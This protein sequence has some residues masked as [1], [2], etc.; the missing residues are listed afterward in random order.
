MAKKKPVNAPGDPLSPDQAKRLLQYADVI[1]DPV[2]GDIQLTSLERFIIDQPE[3]QRLMHINQLGLTYLVYPGALHNRFLHSIGT[4]H[5]CQ[6]MIDACNMSASIYEAFAQPAHPLPVNV[7]TYPAFLARLCAL[8]HDMAHVPFGHIFHNQAH[9]FDR[10]EWED[11]DRVAKTLAPESEFTSRIVDWFHSQAG[12]R[13]SRSDSEKVA[14]VILA[15]VLQVLKTKQKNVHNLPYPFIHDL[16]GNTICADLLDYVVRD[17]KFCGLAERFGD[18]FTRHLGVVPVEASTEPEHAAR[19]VQMTAFRAEGHE[20]FR[21]DPA[22]G[23]LPA[24]ICRLVLLQFR[25]NERHE[26]VVKDNVIS[27]AID[28]VR[29]REA[30]ADKLYFHRTVMVATAMLGTSAC[31][32]GLSAMDIWE[33]SDREVL[34]MLQQSPSRR[35]SRLADKLMKRHLFKSLFRA[36]YRPPDGDDPSE[37]EQAYQTYKRPAN[38]QTLIKK[39]EELIALSTGDAEAA[40]GSVVISCPHTNMNVKAFDMLV[41]NGPEGIDH[42]NPVL[43]RLDDT[44]HAVFGPEIRVIKSAHSRLWKLEVFVDPDVVTLHEPLAAELARAVED[45]LELDNKLPQFDKVTEKDVD[46]LLAEARIETEAATREP[47]LTLKDFRSIR[48]AVLTRTEAAPITIISDE[49]ERRGY[50]R[51]EAT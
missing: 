35:A 43:R 2:H 36:P 40:T 31:E 9:L 5:V 6:Q 1:R 21:R 29:R 26:V 14:R 20:A 7:G 46:V 24:K 50:H 41:L 15:D 37:E 34:K 32:H 45:S 30:I 25:Y 18:R 33:C 44:D 3:F 13:L 38:R 17:M 23:R 19:E 47:S 22:T 4:L 12:L 8:M 48:D 42:K 16:V 27:E 28:L 49:L 39:L 11:E 10:D 51:R